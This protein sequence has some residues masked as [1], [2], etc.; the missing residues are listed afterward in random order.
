[1]TRRRL[2]ILAACFAAVGAA[3][4]MLLPVSEAER[5]YDRIQLGMT[6]DEVEAAVS[7]PNVEPSF[8]TFET[9]M[10]LRGTASTSTTGI[11]AYWTWDN[12]WLITVKFD[13]NDKAAG[14]YLFGPPTPLYRMWRFLG[15]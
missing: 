10:N 6:Y 2:L 14:F 8:E 7:K 3:W 4:W 15:L 11:I 9:V 1:M 12:R 13:E 5:A